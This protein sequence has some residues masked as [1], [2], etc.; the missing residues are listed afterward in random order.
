M[1]RSDIEAKT[2][3]TIVDELD[4]LHQT[5]RGRA[6]DLFRN[7]GTLWGSALTDW[8][9]AE[10]ELVSTPAIELRQKDGR[11]E[12]LA[13]L[14]GIA[15]KDLDVQISPEHLLIKAETAREHVSD[16]GTVHVSE[17]ASGRIFRALRFPE[18]IDPSTAKG[19]YKNGMLRVTAAIEKAETVKKVDVK[20][21]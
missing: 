15:A 14:A 6:Y 13:A 18:R 2:T 7:G 10:R 4:Q 12:V 9:T 21:A 20:A 5:I 11:F 17:L 16:E 8:F 19:E 3:D 1:A